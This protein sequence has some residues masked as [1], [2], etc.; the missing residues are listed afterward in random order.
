MKSVHEK[1]EIHSKDITNMIEMITELQDAPKLPQIPPNMATT[2]DILIIRSRVEY[3]E[4]QQ[5]N[6]K[7]SLTELKKQVEDINTMIKTKLDG[8]DE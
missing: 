6:Q 8:F 3:V 5:V 4:N 2:N 1:L 7:K